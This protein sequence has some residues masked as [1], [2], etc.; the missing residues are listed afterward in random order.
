[1]AL[2]RELVDAVKRGCEQ[3][4]SRLIKHKVTIYFSDWNGDTPLIIAAR[5]GHDGVVSL[6]TQTTRCIKSLSNKLGETAMIAAAKN[7]HANVVRLLI[8]GVNVNH[9]DR[10]GKTALVWAMQMEH[11]DV[12]SILLTKPFNLDAPLTWA[13]T[14]SH[15]RW[16][17]V[18]LDV[19]PTYARIGTCIFQD[20]PL[21][22]AAQNGWTEMVQLLLR[23]N[24]YDINHRNAI[25]DTALIVATRG[26]HANTV[27]F[28]LR[29]PNIS[30][31][32]HNEKRENALIL[33]VRGKCYDIFDMLLARPD[34][35]VNGDDDTP[36]PLV[37]AA[38]RG[39][40]DTVYRLLRHPDIDANAQD[41]RGENALMVA[42]RSRRIGVVRMLLGVPGIRV[43]CI[44]RLAD[45]SALLWASACGQETL[46]GMLLNVPGICVNHQNRNGDS[47]LIKAA[48]SGYHRI[49]IRLLRHPDIVINDTNEQGHTA[50]DE[51]I[52]RGHDQVVMVFLGFPG[53]TLEQ[54][55]DP[56]TGLTE[57][58]R[59]EHLE[60][61]RRAKVTTLTRKRSLHGE[62]VRGVFQSMPRELITEVIDMIL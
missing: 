29:V 52:R 15:S 61:A 51:A 21:T 46:V 35:M 62:V 20:T 8:D 45:M 25:G 40:E 48:Q 23:Y 60:K 31:N 32:I 37:D 3:T 47:A 49:V 24:R 22:I 59:I 38:S 54:A 19:D 30:V 9:V 50:L 12:V 39:F 6:L 44:E 43:N 33:A 16:A 41:W 27:S 7:G 57:W 34:I 28:L 42:T 58:L 1:M 2:E 36:R 5:N 17:K 55:F 14:E 18:L 10:E 13:L 4:V 56:A 53:L 11:N 26:R